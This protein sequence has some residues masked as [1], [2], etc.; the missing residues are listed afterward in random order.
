MKAAALLLAA[1]FCGANDEFD[2]RVKTA[3]EA[4]RN[5]SATQAELSLKQAVKLSPEDADAHALL[6]LALIQGHKRP[7]ALVSYRTAVRLDRRFIDSRSLSRVA[8]ERRFKGEVP[9]IWDLE[10]RNLM[11]EVLNQPKSQPDPLKVRI[12]FPADWL[13]D[14]NSA[15]PNLAGSRASIV[16]VGGPDG[17]DASDAYDWFEKARLASPARYDGYKLHDKKEFDREGANGM[18]LLYTRKVPGYRE[19]FKVYDLILLKEGEYRRAIYTAP[20]SEFLTHSELAVEAI[21]TLQ[22]NL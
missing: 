14:G 4:L 12:K 16:V 18:Q 13:V 9:E 3:L 22:F 15:R 17:F 7:D 11:L 2:A 10:Q 20:V 19:K 6:A 1:A 5:G 8:K 21:Q